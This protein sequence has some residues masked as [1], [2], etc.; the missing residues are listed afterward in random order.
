[1]EDRIARN[2]MIAASTTMMITPK[3]IFLAKSMPY[4]PSLEQRKVGFIALRAFHCTVVFHTCVY[5]SVSN[6]LKPV[7][8]II[9]SPHKRHHVKVTTQVTIHDKVYCFFCCCCLSV[10]NCRN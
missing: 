6:L 5:L 1:M 4:L 2:S 3:K 10:S 7:N 8:A 9:T